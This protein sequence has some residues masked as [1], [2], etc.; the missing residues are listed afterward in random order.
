MNWKIMIASHWKIMLVIIQ[1]SLLA[2]TLA[3]GNAL[4]GE[5]VDTPCGPSI[6][7]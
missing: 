2:I 5:A 6:N 4:A 3:T 1:F 7:T